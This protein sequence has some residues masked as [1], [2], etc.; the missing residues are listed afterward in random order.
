MIISN[1]CN[2]S[3]EEKTSIFDKAKRD[4][5][6]WIW[7]DLNSVLLGMLDGLWLIGIVKVKSRMHKRR[8]GKQD[9]K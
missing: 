1:S 4:K 3:N 7:F 2:I 5:E 8:N 6:Y 9:L